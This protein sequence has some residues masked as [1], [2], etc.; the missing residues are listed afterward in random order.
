M[1][2]GAHRSRWPSAA[3]DPAA[4]ALAELAELLGTG[5]PEEWIGQARCGDSRDDVHYPTGA[6]ESPQY[7]RQVAA[8]KQ[9]CARCP[10]RTEC[11]TYALEQGEDHGIWGGTTPA[12]RRALLRRRSRRDQRRAS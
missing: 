12:E 8:A 3:P 2:G 10:V 9:E 11:L 7:I 4:A 5:E 1:S 6:E